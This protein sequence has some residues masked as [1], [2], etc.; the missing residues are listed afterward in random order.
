[1]K[2][3]AQNLLFAIGILSIA[4]GVYLHFSEVN[5]FNSYSGIVFGVILISGVFVAKKGLDKNN[6]E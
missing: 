1:M 5:K 6:K 4:L 2:K 3:P